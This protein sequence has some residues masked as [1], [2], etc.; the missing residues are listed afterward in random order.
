MEVNVEFFGVSEIGAGRRRFAIDVE[1]TLTARAIL[2]K[3]LLQAE[4]SISPESLLERYL[5]LVDGEHTIY[6]DGLNT[7]VHPGQKIS[8]VAQFGGG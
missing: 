6:G 5:V 4:S 3:V 1:Q 7:A 8:I 2:E